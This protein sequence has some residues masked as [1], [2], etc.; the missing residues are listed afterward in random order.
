MTIKEVKSTLIVAPQ[1]TAKSTKAVSL[2]RKVKSQVPVGTDGKMFE[3]EEDFFIRP[4]SQLRVSSLFDSLDWSLTGRG[5]L[6]HLPLPLSR[7][8]L[9]AKF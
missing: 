7:T 5:R 8:Y 4:S 9:G 3:I 6:P 1:N 2:N